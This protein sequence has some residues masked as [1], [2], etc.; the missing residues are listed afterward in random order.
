VSVERLVCFAHGKESGPWGTKITRLAEVARARGFEV[1]SPDY[2]GTHDPHERVRML[3]D[4]APSARHLVLVGSSM[5]GYVSAM[6]CQRLR[7]SALFLMA[8]AL[9]FTGWDEEPAGIP[10]RCCVVHGWHDDVVPVDRA[11][12]FAERHRAE[13]HLLHSGHTLNDQLPALSFLLDRMLG[14][15]VSS[16]P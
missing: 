7:P 1:M 2:T 8:P 14:A 13:L 11:Q 4:L 3:R 5:G 6:A 9:Y 12:R 10:E 15:V 16:P